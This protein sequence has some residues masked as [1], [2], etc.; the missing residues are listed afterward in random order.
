MNTLVAALAFLAQHADLIEALWDLISKGVSKDRIKAALKQ[1][2][3]EI[4][5]QAMREELG[6]P[7]Q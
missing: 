6:L 3:I 5:D 2:E 1:L 4:S 7:P